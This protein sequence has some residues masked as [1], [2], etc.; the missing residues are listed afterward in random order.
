M[1]NL[2]N[3]GCLFGHDVPPQKLFDRSDWWLELPGVF[4]WYRCPACGLLF[5]SPRPTLAEIVRYYPDTYTPYRRAIEDERWAIM[6]WKRRRNMRMFTDGV[7]RHQPRRGWL[8]DVGCATGT[9]LAQMRRTGW[10]VA[11]VELSP[12]AAA[13]ARERLGLTVFTGDLLAAGLP[14]GQYNAVTLW[15]VLEHTHNPL[16]ILRE[17]KRLL[18]P[19]GLVA[20][21]MPD[22]ASREARTFGREWIGYDTPRHLYLFGGQSLQMVLDAAGFELLEVEHRV[23]TYHTW[24]A[25]MQTRVQQRHGDSPLRRLL[26]KSLGL[27]LWS[28]LSAPWFNTLNRRGQGSVVTVYARPV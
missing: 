1:M 11:G 27:P 24:R 15:D 3:V 16:A 26:L 2:E 8:L 19:G 23:A 28:V 9:F 13:Y 18:A 10:Q 12:T 7:N 20:F 21:S 22:P 6:R 25:S 4:T 14:A 5:L 17:I